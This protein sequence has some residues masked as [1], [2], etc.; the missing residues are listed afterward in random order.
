MENI[1]IVEAGSTGKNLVQDVINRNYNPVVLELKALSDSKE[2]E[3]YK[4]LLETSY[5]GIKSDFELIYE[6]DTYEET[7][8]MVR[9]LNPKIIL[10]ASENGVRIATKLS[11]DLNLMGNP[12]ENLDA[13]TLKNEMQ[14][15]LAQNNLRHIRGKAVTS[16]DEAI[17]YYEQEGFDE[18]VVKPAIGGASVG[19]KICLNKEEM[20]NAVTELLNN[21]NV[22]GDEVNEAVIQERIKGEEYIVNTMSHKGT[23]RVTTIWKYNKVTTPEGYHIYNY[24]KS[25]D[26]LGLGESEIVEY[27]YDVADA[28]GIQY[29]PIHGEYMVDENGPVLIEVNCR[30]MGGSMDAEFLDKLSGQHETDSILDSYLNPEKF[31]KDLKKGYKLYGH[32][33]LKFFIVPN[34]VVAKSAPMNYISNRLKSHYKTILADVNELQPFPKTQDLETSCG[35]TYLFNEDGHQVRNDLEFLE[36]IEKNAFQLVLSEGLDKPVTIDESELHEYIKKLISDIKET[37]TCLLITDYIYDDLDI[38][39]ITPQKLNE[40]NG[41]FDSI[42]IN[43]NKSIV[44]SRDDEIVKFVLDTFDRIKSGGLVFIPKTTYD[45]MPSGGLGAEALVRALALKIELPI[46]N[47]ARILIAS[48]R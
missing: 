1:L 20:I 40:I 35:T 48:K 19:V 36:S 28:I 44:G 7:L 31:Y 2:A 11:H 23:H 43:L 10:P 17:E 15:R 5:D 24:M 42:V 30:A 41:E 29:G 37:G 18:V 22:F 45:A 27:A 39:Q 13:M 9:E 34:Y 14:N 12:I 38:L 26:E 16:P 6:K 3:M 47:Y 4:E 46:H 8:E 21:H 25:I 32:A 33:A